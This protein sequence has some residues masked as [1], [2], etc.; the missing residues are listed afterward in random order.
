MHSIIIII[1]ESLLRSLCANVSL[2]TVQ[3]RSS[4]LWPPPHHEA[5]IQNLNIQALLPH[6]LKNELLT[7]GEYEEIARFKDT[8]TE[9]NQHFIL[10]VLPRKGQSAHEKFVESLKAERQHLGHRDL[11]KLLAT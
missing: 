4:N 1:V 2:E 5:L 9:Q 7:Q 6:L 3:K 10:A 8:P 11:V